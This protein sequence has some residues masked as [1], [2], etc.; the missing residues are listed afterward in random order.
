[1]VSVAQAFVKPPPRLERLTGPDPESRSDADYHGHQIFDH[2]HGEVRC[3]GGEVVNGTGHGEALARLHVPGALPVLPEGLLVE[4]AGDHDGRRHGVQHA[5]HADSHH[6]L[7]QLLRLG[8]IVL[9]DGA[10]AKQGHETGQEER[11]ADEEVHKQRCQDEAPQGVYVED[12]HEAHPSQD[13]SLHLAHGEDGDGL[14]GWDRPRS[15]VEVLGVGF[16]RFVAPFHPSREKP[17]QGQNHPPDGA[18][19]TKKVQHHEENGAAFLLGALSHSP[20]AVV[21]ELIHTHHFIFQEK[22]SG[23]GH[24][25]HEIAARQEDNG[26]LWVS[27]A[28]HVH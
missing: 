27:E 19:H 11:R 21:F 2:E 18:G 1:M 12:P 15:Q 14:D 5:E 6:Q 22:S 9:H 7:L 24:R 23:V 25:H 26:P 13:V 28:S 4:V 8:A 17:G 16:N 10:N 20:V 3:H